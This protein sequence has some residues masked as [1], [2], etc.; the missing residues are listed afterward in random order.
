MEFLNL[1]E[2]TMEGSVLIIFITLIRSLFRKKLDPNIRYFLWFFVAVRVLIPFKLELSVELPEPRVPYSFGMRMEEERQKENGENGNSGQDVFQKAAG[3]FSIPAAKKGISLTKGQVLFL[4]WLCGAGLMA[5]YVLLVNIK[6]RMTLKAGRRKIGRLPCRIPLYAVEGYNCLTGI[7]FPAIYVDMDGLNDSAVA[8]DV[9]CHELQHYRVRDN[10]WQG[11]RVLCLILQWH[12][13]FM[14][15]AYFASGRDCELAC[16]ARVVR[17]MSKA[18]RYEYGNSLLT[19]LECAV[20]KK[21]HIGFH[22]SMGTDKKFVSERINAIMKFQSKKTIILSMAVITVIGCV[23]FVSFRLRT[24]AGT[25][26]SVPTDLIVKTNEEKQDN[27]GTEETEETGN[28]DITAPTKEEVLAMREQVLEGMSVEETERLKENIK[29]ANLRMES[30][31]LNDNIFEK[32]EDE[33]SLYW[34]YFDQKGEIQVGWAY[35][36]SY[37]E[38]RAVMEDENLTQEEFYAK[39]GTPVTV[40]NRFDAGNFMELLQ[41]MKET[42]KNEKLQADLQQIIDETA[43]AVETHEMEHVLHIYRLLHD[44]D[45]YLLRYGLED[46][47]KYVRDVSTI[48]KYYGVL[49]VYE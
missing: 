40:Y 47:G 22:T 17:G 32:L 16:D 5:L 3:A 37:Q 14:W 48:A 4:L 33:E 12:N 42:V 49:Q 9:L 27:A 7:L 1:V 2:I 8:K 24:E 20:Q 28:E 34:N 25:D 45:Y 11:L 21:Q 19:V 44:M 13:P 10:Y 39:Y 18:E 35:E 38:M 30:A 6:L 15:W 36:G 23:C 43:L 41:E 46:V 26:D 31:Y 29:V